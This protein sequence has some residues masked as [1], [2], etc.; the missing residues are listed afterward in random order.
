MTVTIV[1]A[2]G[3][4][5]VIGKDG[6]LP[7]Y[8]P[9][10]FAHFKAL[11]VG[12][13]LIMGRLT[14]ESIGRPLPDRTTIVVTRDESWS[15]EGV[16]RASD[17]SEA[18][19]IA[20][21]YDDE[22]FVAGGAQIYT[23]ALQ[24][25][26]VDAMVISEVDAEPE[27]DT[28]FHRPEGWRPVERDRRD[29]FAIVTYVPRSADEA[30]ESPRRPSPGHRLGRPAY[31]LHKLVS[32]LDRAADTMLRESHGF[33]YSRYLLLCVID[34]IDHGTQ[35]DIAT[36]LSVSEPAV[37]KKISDAVSD[38]LVVR[39]HEPGSGHR[40][41]ISLTPAGERILIDCSDRLEEALSSLLHRAG[42]KP[43]DIVDPA[44][45]VL[46]AME[47]GDDDHPG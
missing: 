7:W 15:H 36:M 47:E 13:P 14:F 9:E 6:A 31:T 33:T 29:G 30:V 20:Q 26:L 24:L 25:G 17:V 28:W 37:S 19:E 32:N 38:G 23:E 4:N 46:R 39:S 34:D 35:R 44:T 22:V 45:R 8:L 5:G 2:Q 11:T 16:I 42:L 27:G 21:E 40:L 12:H 41:S 1:L 3:R 43:G 10:D 18:V